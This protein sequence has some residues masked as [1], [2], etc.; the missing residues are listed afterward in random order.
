[1]KVKKDIKNLLD[2][3]PVLIEK[4]VYTTISNND[5]ETILT[6]VTKNRCIDILEVLFEYGVDINMK[7]DNNETALNSVIIKGVPFLEITHVL[8]DYGAN[9]NI[10]DSENRTT[11]EKLID[12]ILITKKSKKKSKFL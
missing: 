6:I 8:L 9:P 12:A 3:I 1:M 10:K 2:F 5:H 7:S 4:G 11:I